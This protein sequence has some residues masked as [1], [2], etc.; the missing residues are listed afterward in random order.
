MGGGASKSSSDVYTRGEVATAIDRQ[1]STQKRLQLESP[2]LAV[3][4]G[5]N[6]VF[7]PEPPLDPTLV[8]RLQQH[9]P[10]ELPYTAAI[11]KVVDAFIDVHVGWDKVGRGGQAQRN[12]RWGLQQQAVED[13]LEQLNALLEGWKVRLVAEAGAA[14]TSLVDQKI[15]VK[16]VNGRVRS[17]QATTHTV[18]KETRIYLVFNEGEEAEALESEAPVVATA[19]AQDAPP[20]AGPGAK[21][22][23]L[24]EL[25]DAGAITQE[26]FDASKTKLLEQMTG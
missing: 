21:I 26:E 22:K 24:K 13:A 16:T 14:Q 3:L 15:K 9:F 18:T 17:Q 4:H 6:W 10:P 8:A 19:V 20:A 1:L 5:T 25:L 2:Q 23:E 7:N 12:E 11:R